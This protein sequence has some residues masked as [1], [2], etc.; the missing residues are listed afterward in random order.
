MAWSLFSSKSV[1]SSFVHFGR[2]GI[3][4][5]F[6]RIHVAKVVFDIGIEVAR[7]DWLVMMVVGIWPKILM[8]SNR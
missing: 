6:A 3:I 2:S 5:A 1:T 7:V 4:G 8:K